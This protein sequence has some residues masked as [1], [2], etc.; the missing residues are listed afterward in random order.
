MHIFKDI[1]LTDYHLLSWQKMAKP[2]RTGSDTS[3]VVKQGKLTDCDFLVNKCLRE[4]QGKTEA[5]K[6]GV[7]SVHRVRTGG[8]DE[9][10]RQ[11]FIY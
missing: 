4:D 10:I 7:L 11:V 2:C 3:S 9:G 8:F 5:R 6:R 1:V